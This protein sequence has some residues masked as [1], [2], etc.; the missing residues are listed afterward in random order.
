MIL[1][2]SFIYFSGVYIYVVVIGV[3]ILALPEKCQ[4]Y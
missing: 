3:G 1:D 4:I 2:A